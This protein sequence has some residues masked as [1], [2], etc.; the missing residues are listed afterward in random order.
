M[1]E[2][3][4]LDTSSAADNAE[5]VA[6][7]EL[8]RTLVAEGLGSSL[9]TFLTVAAG[10]LA[11]RYAIGNTDLA[12]AMTAATAAAAFAVL[13]AALRGL[14]PCCFNPAFALSLALT[15]A[16]PVTLALLTTVIQIGAAMFGIVL[17]H[18]VAN[19][20]P[21]QTATQIHSGLP[22]WL[23]EFLATGLVVLAFLRLRDA[24]FWAVP[25]LGGWALQAAALAT[26]SLPLANPAATLARGLTD[27]FTSIRLSD[28]A[29]ILACQLGGACG[30][31]LL[32][33]WLF[34]VV[35]VP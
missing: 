9:L 2:R 5:R 34:P 32:E 13:S 14:A 24:G 21:V 31:A 8:V 28:A 19:T 1:L 27:S 30:A 18:I 3:R 12:I 26:P 23:G 10:I 16:L 29:L 6:T 4:K 33:R 22:T 17:A 7:P 15:R 35:K 11:E 20:G 25:V